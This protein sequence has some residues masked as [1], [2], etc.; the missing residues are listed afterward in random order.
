MA[1]TN[2]MPLIRGRPVIGVSPSLPCLLDVPFVGVP[3]LACVRVPGMDVLHTVSDHGHFDVIEETDVDLLVSE[4]MD[5]VADDGR[6]LVG[7]HG[8]V[9]LLDQRIKLWVLIAS[10]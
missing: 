2:R 8:A 4:V 5:D 7:R 10:A 6:A 9:E 1:P 3:G